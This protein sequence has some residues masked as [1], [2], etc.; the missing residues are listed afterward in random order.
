[1]LAGVIFAAHGRTSWGLTDQREAG[2]ADCEARAG[3]RGLGPI[4]WP[5]GWPS[6]DL[7][8][9][10]AMLH[11]ED[12]G[13]LAPFALAA[14]RLGFLEG[15]SVSELETVLEAAARTGLDPHAL[16]HAIAQP[17]LKEALRRRNDEAL[18]Q[19]VFGVPTVV[20]GGELF[21]GDDRLEDAARAAGSTRT[22]VN[23]APASRRDSG[24]GVPPPR[25]DRCAGS[26]TG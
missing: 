24:H 14:M 10:R 3:E 21:W 5:P 23:G 4:R 19:G 18:A 11:A 17:P 2:L 12:E 16:E 22:A 26:S 25:L 15:R 6:S 20:V 8:V 7:I 1:M 9:T 13:A